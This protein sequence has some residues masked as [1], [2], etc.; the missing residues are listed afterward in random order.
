M[1][2]KT[3]YYLDDDG[4]LW[5]TIGAQ[6]YFFSRKKRKWIAP[7]FIFKIP[8]WDYKNKI[9]EDQANKVL[10][11]YKKEGIWEYEKTP[12]RYYANDNDEI[13]ALDVYENE[14]YVLADLTLKPANKG[15][16]DCMWRGVTRDE[17]ETFVKKEY[18]EKKWILEAAGSRLVRFI[19]DY[20]GII[21]LGDYQGGLPKSEIG[22][23]SEVIL[24]DGMSDPS[25][26]AF[27]EAAS[28]EEL[29]KMT[30]FRM[31]RGSPITE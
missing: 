14:F 16:I 24:D 27:F 13:F 4:G 15:T 3:K 17:A 31:N 10:A 30:E 23:R 5:K 11:D 12:I 26:V 28:I 1:A 21:W 20:K 8:V 29:K 22:Y 7:K 25:A 19:G 6:A 18:Q 2:E 9:T